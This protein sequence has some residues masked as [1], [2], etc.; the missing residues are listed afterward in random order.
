MM[1]VL[2][3][4]VG[5]IIMIGDHISISLAGMRGNAVSLAIQA[6][7]EYAVL[8]KEIYDFLKEE[9]LA[10]SR[11][12]PGQLKE[13]A[14]YFPKHVPSVSPPIYQPDSDFISLTTKKFGAIKVHQDQIIS[15]IPG[16]VGF[17]KC[18]TFA[19]LDDLLA[20]PFQVLQCLGEPGLSFIVV[21]PP[22]IFPNYQIQALKKVMQELGAESPEDL[23][24]LI[25]LTIPPDRPREMTANLLGPLLINRR[26]R[27]GKKV[28]LDKRDYSSQHRVIPD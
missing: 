9:N 15:I 4:K 6:P 28:V 12:D 17:C 16:P 25:I 7:E 14:P 26:T 21:E 18:N 10:A 20:P 2:T 11:S 8:R 23:Q 24:V 27:R 3:R 13:L 22:H 5:E 19:L 1:L